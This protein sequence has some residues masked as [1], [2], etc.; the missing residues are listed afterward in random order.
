[1]AKNRAKKVRAAEDI[2]K[3]DFLRLIEKRGVY[4]HLTKA[5]L[6]DPEFQTLVSTLLAMR[7]AGA[8]PNFIAEFDV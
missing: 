3:E 6:K 7:M 5:A 2:T 4:I 8:I 1:M